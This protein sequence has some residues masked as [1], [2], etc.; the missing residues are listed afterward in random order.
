M[1]KDITFLKLIS[2]CYGAGRAGGMEL[3]ALHS[4]YMDEVAKAAKRGH[5]VGYNRG[6]AVGFV[7]GAIVPVLACVAWFV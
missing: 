7:M 1:S 5:N 3:K 2:A 6:L 4:L